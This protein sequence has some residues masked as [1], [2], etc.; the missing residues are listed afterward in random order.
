MKSGVSR[1]QTEA[2]NLPQNGTPSLT[3]LGLPKPGSAGLRDS[4]SIADLEIPQPSPCPP[5]AP[6][7]QLG[8]LAAAAVMMI[9]STAHVP[10][11]YALSDTDSVRG[12]RLEPPGSVSELADTGVGQL[13]DQSVKRPRSERQPAGGEVAEALG[14]LLARG[15][16]TQSLEPPP[17]R[18]TRQPASSESAAPRRVALDIHGA[19][20][21][22]IPTAMTRESTRPSSV[23][24]RPAP[25]PETGASSSLMDTAPSKPVVE[26]ALAAQTGLE[27]YNTGNLRPAR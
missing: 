25:Y 22:A 27:A 15:L 5:A 7:P 26:I 24:A 14:Y 8:S 20:V 19:L 2:R 1:A 18:R 6:I 4:R 16:A 9:T 10:Y 12:P 11:D 23:D 13:G 3:G 21:M 17:A